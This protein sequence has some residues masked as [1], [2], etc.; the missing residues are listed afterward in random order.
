N[1]LMVSTPAPVATCKA[2][3]TPPAGPE[4][5]VRTG[6][7]AATCAEMLPPDDCMTR[8]LGTRASRALAGETPAYPVRRDRYLPINGCRYAFTTTV[9]VRSYSRYSGRTSCEIE[10]GSLSW[11]R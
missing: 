7:R 6:S 5:I 8:K 3:T 11:P 1:A 2:P 4:R 9:D 10:I